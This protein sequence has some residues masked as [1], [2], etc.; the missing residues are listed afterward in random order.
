MHR[1]RARSA[2]VA[3]SCSPYCAIRL[4]PDTE[5]GRIRTPIPDEPGHAIRTKADTA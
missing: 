3:R 2:V 4:K 1:R 5:Y